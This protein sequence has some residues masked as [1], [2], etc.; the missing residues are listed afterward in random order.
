[1]KARIALCLHCVV[2]AHSLL[3]QADE[4]VPPDG[5]VDQIVTEESVTTRDVG[6]RHVHSGYRDWRLR[7]PVMIGDFVGGSLG[8]RAD[9]V[10]ERLIVLADD[11]DAP[12]VLPGENSPLSISEPGPVGIFS[13]SLS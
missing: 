10:R 6:I 11:L 7:S 2:F 4:Q 9:S 5:Q 1:M 8:F 13:S 12:M 3:A